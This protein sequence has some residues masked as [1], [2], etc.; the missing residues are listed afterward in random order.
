VPARRRADTPTTECE[1]CGKTVKLA[2]LANHKAMAHDPD[3]PRRK[4]FMAGVV[5][6]RKKA[7]KK[8]SG[9]APAKPAPTAPLEGEPKT[10]PGF[11]DRKLFGGE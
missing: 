10:K 8:T 1:V 11:W 6:R 3:N 7:C 4:A 5:A 2:G 9:K